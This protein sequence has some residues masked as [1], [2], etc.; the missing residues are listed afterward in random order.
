MLIHQFLRKSGNVFKNKPLHL[1]ICLPKPVFRDEFIFRFPK[2]MWWKFFKFFFANLR[3]LSVNWF[4]LEPVYR[5]KF[6]WSVSLSVF[7]KIA[8]CQFSQK[9]GSIYKI[10]PVYLQTIL[11]RRIFYPNSFSAPAPTPK[12]NFL[13]IL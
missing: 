2:Y 6:L 8:V 7:L 10:E 5:R 3:N 4:I 13:P 11:L 12:N 1:A 9:S